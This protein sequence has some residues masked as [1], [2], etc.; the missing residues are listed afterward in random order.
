MWQL[1]SCETSFIENRETNIGPSQKKFCTS[2]NLMSPH[3]S[4]KS[5]NSQ[6][7]HGEVHAVV[8]IAFTYS[9][10]VLQSIHVNEARITAEITAQRCNCVRGSAFHVPHKSVKPLSYTKKKRTP[11]TPNT[12]LIAL[13]CLTL[14][15]EA[16][17][18]SKTLVIITQS[19]RR[20]L[21]PGQPSQ[22]GG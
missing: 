19:T 14:N 2:S 9:S 7:V 20:N 10:V 8:Q 21:R 17:C 5:R 12:F 22:Y 15:L 3:W 11:S 16:L 1:L 13:G 4:L 6:N 18:S